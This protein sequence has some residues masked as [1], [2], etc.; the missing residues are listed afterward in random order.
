MER[1]LQTCGRPTRNCRTTNRVFATKLRRAGPNWI[2]V[3]SSPFGVS[4]FTPK[5]DKNEKLEKADVV[6]QRLT[7]NISGHLS[8]FSAPMGSLQRVCEMPRDPPIIRVREC[9]DSISRLGLRLL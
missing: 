3:P 8:G 9:F 7:S 2:G 6:T 5:P 4:R 1:R